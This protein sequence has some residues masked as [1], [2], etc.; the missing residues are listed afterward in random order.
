MTTRE[1]LVK[2]LIEGKGDINRIIEKLSEYSYDSEP[3]AVLTRENV[4]KLLKS[5]LEGNIS[6]KD[7]QIWAD[8]VEMRDDIDYEEGFEQVIADQLYILSEPEINGPLNGDTVKNIIEE[9]K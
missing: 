3:L 8:A 7:I 1:E 4:I 2:S 6:S 5:F 9:L